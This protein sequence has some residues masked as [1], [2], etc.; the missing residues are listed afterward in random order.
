MAETLFRKNVKQANPNQGGGL[1]PSN[2]VD[3][4]KTQVGDD[5]GED[6]QDID[7]DEP[8][9]DVTPG[10]GG[11]NGDEDLAS[12]MTRSRIALGVD[13]NFSAPALRDLLSENGLVGGPSVYEAKLDTPTEEK[14]I[15]ND[16]TIDFDDDSVWA[17]PT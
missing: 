5:L 7:L 4:N 11:T 15:L 12:G 3:E 17:M 16:L 6:D 13:L 14:V 1:H 9:D 2:P 8:D 10:I